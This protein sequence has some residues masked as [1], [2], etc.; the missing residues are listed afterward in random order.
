MIIFHMILDITL[1][2]INY[3]QRQAL[4]VMYKTLYTRTTYQNTWMY[5]WKARYSFI[6]LNGFFSNYMNNYYIQNNNEKCLIENGYI[7]QN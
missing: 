2:H 1:F 3:Q 5:N 4:A 7:C 6:K